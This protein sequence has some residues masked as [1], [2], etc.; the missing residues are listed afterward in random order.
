MKTE[1]D[2]K[3]FY[4][5]GHFDKDGK[6]RYIGSGSKGRAVTFCQRQKS[7]NAVFSPIN[8]PT[9]KLFYQ[10]LSK[11]A[12]NEKEI[13][14][15]KF[16]ENMGEPLI[17]VIKSTGF[18][19]SSFSKEDQARL[20]K[21][22]SGKNHYNYGKKLSDDV[23]KKISSTLKKNP[24]SYWL[25]KKRDKSTMINS[26]KALN[27]PNNRAKIYLKTRGR[28]QSEEEKLKRMLSAHRKKIMCNETKEVFLSI[29]DASRK[30]N[31]SCGHICDH[32][33]GKLKH[34]KKLTFSRVSKE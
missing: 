20:G 32:I 24:V 14:L 29:N 3:I 2:Q 4:V 25:G 18:N 23:K 19:F 26:I 30:L 16:Y 12:A 7:W 21:L 13:E 1:N 8:K 17:N 15:I 34:V 11:I 22:R 6:L 31:L 28:K 5:Y 33:N 9:V 10:N 27:D